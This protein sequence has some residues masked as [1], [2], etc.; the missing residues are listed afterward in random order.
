MYLM[1]LELLIHQIGGA[2]FILCVLTAI[3]R[4]VCICIHVQ[5]CVI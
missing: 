2:L 4:Y 1:L 3:R 5:V